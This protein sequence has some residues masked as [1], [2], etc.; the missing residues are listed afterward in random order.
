V[1]A[2]DTVFGGTVAHGMLTLS[3]MSAMA[4]SALPEMVGQSASINYG[5]EKL[6]FISPVQAGA[7]IRGQFV[8]AEAQM[9]A[10][11]KLMCRFDVSVEIE[12]YRR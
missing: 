12:G 1:R 7:R 2:A 11:D 5:F 6:R 10:G 3:M 4:Y 8:A 9:R